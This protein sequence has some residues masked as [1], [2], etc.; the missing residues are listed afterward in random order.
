MNAAVQQNALVESIKEGLTAERPKGPFPASS[1]LRE[2]NERCI[3]RP[4]EPT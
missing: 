3:L 2:T 4:K 1:T